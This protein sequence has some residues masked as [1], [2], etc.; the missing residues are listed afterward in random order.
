MASSW[1]GA[2]R[3]PDRWRAMRSASRRARRRTGRFSVRPVRCSAI[4]LAPPV[5]TFWWHSR[6]LCAL[7][8]GPRPSAAVSTSSKM[9]R[10][11]LNDRNATTLSSFNDSYA[12]PWV[13]KP[14]VTPSKPV[15]ASVAAAA[16]PS[17]RSSGGNCPRTENRSSLGRNC[18]G[19]WGWLSVCRPALARARSVGS[20]TRV[21]IATTP[22]QR[23]LI[24]VISAPNP[25]VDSAS[26]GI[27]LSI[28]FNRPIWLSRRHATP[29]R[30][31][32]STRPRGRRS[33][34]CSM[35]RKPSNGFR[36]R[37]SLSGR[38]TRQRTANVRW[39]C[40]EGPH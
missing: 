15:G 21:A 8:V 26:H 25:K 34:C 28:A 5:A 4:W 7:Y 6:Q 17:A 39:L 16:S 1:A 22:A 32:T 23:G 14:L 18:I 2:R 31:I 13:L 33:R 40:R 9:K 38:T 27:D 12:G 11:S 30:A 37:R 35:P 20:A 3:Y 10:L 29:E 19:S 36:D 24:I